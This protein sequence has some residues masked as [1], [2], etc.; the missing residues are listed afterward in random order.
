MSSGVGDSR[1][2]TI[3]DVEGEDVMTT[4]SIDT[5]IYGMAVRGKAIYYCAENNGLKMLNISDKTK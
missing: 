1:C 2:L 3:I 4:I 5:D